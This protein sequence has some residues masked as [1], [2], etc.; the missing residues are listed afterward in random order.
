MIEPKKDKI[1]QVRISTTDYDLLL[2]YSKKFNISIGK[3]IRMLV[4]DFTISRKDDT[5]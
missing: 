5:K 3:L 4:Y 2:R 1:L